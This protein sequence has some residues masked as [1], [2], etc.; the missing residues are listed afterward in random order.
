MTGVFFFCCEQETGR[1]RTTSTEKIGRSTDGRHLV[2]NCWYRRDGY[3]NGQWRWSLRIWSG[4]LSPSEAWNLR[5]F[6]FLCWRWQPASAG[7]E[8][9]PLHTRSGCRR[10]G[11]RPLHPV[12]SLEADCPLSK[13]TATKESK[14]LPCSRLPLAQTWCREKEDTSDCS[15][16]FPVQYTNF[17]PPLNSHN[18]FVGLYSIGCLFSLDESTPISQ[19]LCGIWLPNLL[20]CFQQALSDFLPP[21]AHYL[22]VSFEAKNVRVRCAYGV[23]GEGMSRVS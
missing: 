23:W 9:A 17:D 14:S 19:D 4:K 13:I 20:S 21:I 2:T 3:W 12:S 5:C 1:T 11:A 15:K 10:Q 18:D 6:L 22:F 16:S 8:E 7:K